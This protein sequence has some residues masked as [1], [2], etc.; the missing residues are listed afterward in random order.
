MERLNGWQRLWVLISLLL[1]VLT[2]WAGVDSWRNEETI[3]G[4]HNS[5]VRSLQKTLDAKVAGK[6]LS[7]T[8]DHY[9]YFG[10]ELSVTELKEKIA[11]ENS[12]HAETIKGL[13]AAK[14]NA[15]ISGILLWAGACVIL[16]VMGWLIGW[17]YRGFRPKAA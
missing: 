4:W 6:D 3:T 7:S 14:R 8:K 15:V 16:Y 5:T 9:S 13:P 10:A 1:A 2:I 12:E 17:I 11:T